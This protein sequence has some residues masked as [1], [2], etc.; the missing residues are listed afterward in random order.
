[1]EMPAQ[2]TRRIC[3]P[4]CCG[5]DRSKPPRAWPPWSQL[6]SGFASP[7]L[8]G[9]RR[10][11]ASW[12]WGHHHRPRHPHHPGPDQRHRR[13]ADMHAKLTAHQLL[14]LSIEYHHGPFR[15]SSRAWCKQTRARLSVCP[16]SCLGDGVRAAPWQRGQPAKVSSFAHIEP[17]PRW[18]TVLAHTLRLPLAGR[19]LGN[20]L[21]VGVISSAVVAGPGFGV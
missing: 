19:K 17:L 7:L 15:H 18:P 1:M 16:V 3:T 14:Q 10:W 9:T 8:L 4:A 20:F 13:E 6:T 5:A 11:A 12:C 2:S 21:Q